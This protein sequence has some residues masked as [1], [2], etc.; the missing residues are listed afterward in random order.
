VYALKS[1]E[2]LADED[3]AQFA[4]ANSTLHSWPF[5]REFLNTLTSRMGFPPFTLGVMHFVPMKPA[6][7]KKDTQTETPKT[8]ESVSQ[9]GE[10]K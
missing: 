1:K 6:P 10:V 9:V 2:P 7:E 8:E 4:D 3:V 5:V